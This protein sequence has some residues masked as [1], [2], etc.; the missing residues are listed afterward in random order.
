MKALEPKIIQKLKEFKTISNMKRE[1]L[2]V[3]INMLSEMELKE[4]IEA[5]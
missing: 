5:F 4:L 3:L 2:R 1:T